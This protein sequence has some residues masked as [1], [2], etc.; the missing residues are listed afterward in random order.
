MG[1]RGI[2]QAV[3][4]FPAPGYGTGAFKEKPLGER[5]LRELRALDKR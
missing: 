5:T 3:G 4:M 1:N 2:Y